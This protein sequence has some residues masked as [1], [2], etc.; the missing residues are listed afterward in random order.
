MNWQ[1]ELLVISLAIT[2]Y[3][4][5]TRFNGST[6]DLPPGVQEWRAKG[7]Y[8]VHDNH[9][10]FYVDEKTSHKESV[11][12]RNLLLLHGF[13]TSS[14]DF[15]K[16]W[17]GLTSKF[18]RIV[19]VD[20]LGYGL[21]DKP[22]SFN[23]TL[24]YQATMVEDLLKHLGIE[25]TH[26]LAH[27][28]GDTVFQEL[29]ARYQ[30]RQT[31][32]NENSGVTYQSVCLLNGAVFPGEHRPIMIQR[33]LLN[34]Y[35]GPIVSS[36]I[37]YSVFK[38]NFLKI[39]GHDGDFDEQEDIMDYWSLVNHNQGSKIYNKLIKYMND[40]TDH[41]DRWVNALRKNK[42]KTILINGPLDPVSGR[43]AAER[44]SKECP[45]ASVVILKDNI[46]HYPQAES[47]KRVIEEYHKFL[48]TL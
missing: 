48:E 20:F 22:V 35:T 11:K 10:V 29:L 45:D 14:Y 40:R 37:S 4:L 32:S 24:H 28:V 27:D 34:P 1:R 15:K 18:S 23:Y 30:E 5:Y 3:L 39:I 7:R 41:K 19:A 21:S 46:G 6:F 44:F 13:P 12:S 8:Y 42:L 33:L 31:D 43:H 17:P 38:T 9:G 2:A 36:F 16:I 26:I 47:P 25:H